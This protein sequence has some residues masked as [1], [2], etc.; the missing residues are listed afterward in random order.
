MQV[1]TVNSYVKFY[2]GVRASQISQVYQPIFYMY[3]IFIFNL[4][5][6]LIQNDRYY[7]CLFFNDFLCNFYFLK[8]QITDKCDGNGSQDNVSRTS[9]SGR[10]FDGGNYSAPKSAEP[11]RL[12]PDKLGGSG[13]V[14]GISASGGRS[15][16]GETK[17]TISST[18]KSSEKKKK[19]TAWYNV[20]V[21]F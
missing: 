2:A 12:D 19:S 4:L 14:G 13:M 20:S 6:S 10:S 7:I 8:N 5:S 21:L 16:S 11:S 18:G 3:Q 1:E 9:E 15:S 17:G